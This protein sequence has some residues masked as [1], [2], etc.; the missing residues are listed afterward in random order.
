MSNGTSIKCNVMLP[1]LPILMKNACLKA[2]PCF[3]LVVCKRSLAELTLDLAFL[4]Q[5]RF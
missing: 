3:S 5:Y 4:M 2:N 1:K